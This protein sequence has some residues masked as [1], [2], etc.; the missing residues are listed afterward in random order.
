MKKV[1]YGLLLLYPPQPSRPSSSRLRLP[2]RRQHE[3]KSP[4]SL[5][6]ESC[7][8]RRRKLKTCFGWFPRC[9]Q[10]LESRVFPIYEIWLPKHLSFMIIVY[11]ELETLLLIIMR[12]ERLI[13]T[14]KQS[15]RSFFLP[16]LFIDT[17]LT[18]GGVYT[19]DKC[20]MSGQ[21]SSRGRRCQLLTVLNKSLL[22]LGRLEQNIFQLKIF[23]TRLNEILT[24]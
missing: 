22:V 16:N 21:Q 19:V 5:L 9:S 4:D 3:H 2:R 10:P 8:E 23:F 20:Y 13:C 24:V 12:S 11:A 15:K 1:R 18:F 6:S 7:F 14:Y 17:V